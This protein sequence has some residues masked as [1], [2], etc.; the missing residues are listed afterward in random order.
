MDLKTKLH[1]SPKKQGLDDKSLLTPRSLVEVFCKTV[2][3]ETKSAPTPTVKANPRLQQ[4]KYG[5]VLTTETVLSRLKEAEEKKQGKNRKKI[6]NKRKV[7]VGLDAQKKKR[8]KINKKR[9]V[10]QSDD[11]DVEEQL[12]LLDNDELQDIDISFED[13][14]VDYSAPTESSVKVGA[15]VLVRVLSGKR[16]SVN[17]T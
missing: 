6:N 7:S 4:L 15:Y 11:S 12:P 16:K 17:Y 2:R 13:D 14:Q 8:E 10:E 3:N 5:E 1:P 9:K